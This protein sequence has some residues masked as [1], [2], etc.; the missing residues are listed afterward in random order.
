MLVAGADS[1]GA[2]PAA[3]GSGD[4]GVRPAAL[5]FRRG[6]RAPTRPLE[7]PLVGMVQVD[8]EPR[9]APSEPAAEAQDSAAPAVN[10]RPRKRG[11]RGPGAKKEV[12]AAAAEA[13]PVEAKKPRRPRA[14][15][16]G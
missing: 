2:A 8:D 7:L 11:A 3:P 9:D 15:K 12:G 1:N 10:G 13:A 6:S 4:S 5:R 14:K 16:S